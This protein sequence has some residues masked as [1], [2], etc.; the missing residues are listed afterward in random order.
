MG[1][2]SIGQGG[3]DILDKALE[4]SLAYKEFR[5]SKMTKKQRVATKTCCPSYRGAR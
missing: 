2:W 4:R 1:C 5:Y 3:H